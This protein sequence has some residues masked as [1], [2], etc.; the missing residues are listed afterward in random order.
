M[1]D[2]IRQV[3]VHD[4]AGDPITGLKWT[5]KATENISRE[6]SKA[7][8]AVSPKTAGRLLKQL[9]YSL[10][11]NHKQIS[12]AKS[13]DRNKQ[14]E[15]IQRTRRAFERS[16]QP[17][18]S[19]DTK[20]KEVVGQFK[21]PG[22]VLARE[23]ILV[24]D[25]D[26]RSEGIGMAVPYGLY[27]TLTNRGHI[28]VGTSHDTAEFAVEAMVRW[29]KNDG[30]RDYP[31][32]KRLLILADN[33]GGNGSK[34]RAWKVYLQ[35]KLADEFGLAVTVCHYP[36]GTSKWNPIEHRLFSEVSK[37]WAGQPLNSYETIL[38]YIR[39]TTTNSGLR[40]DA[41]LVE[42]DFPIGVKIPDSDMSTLRLRPA[43][44]LPAWNYTLLPRTAQ[45]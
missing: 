30:R 22:K 21:N 34:N 17:T 33:G 42:G 41:T 37:N 25:H 43:A 45:M 26:F 18:I 16:G 8:I 15:K 40:V 3:M 20:K 12:S 13:P 36:P 44:I 19:V 10:R 11:V 32:A 27:E 38:N 31:G 28:F 2:A 7:G 4:T 24:R 35:K 23:P 39:T 14:F 9:G 29:W 6:L 5:R 1:I